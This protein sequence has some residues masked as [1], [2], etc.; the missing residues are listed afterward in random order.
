MSMSGN[1]FGDWIRGWLREF[2]GLSK[3][4]WVA[5]ALIM[6]QI[7]V[8]ASQGMVMLVLALS[9]MA[10]IFSHVFYLGFG[11]GNIL[12]LNSRIEN[13]GT[14]RI[15][16]MRAGI[17]FASPKVDTGRE[18]RFD[19]ETLQRGVS[20][21]GTTGSGKTTLLHAAA[22]EAIQQGGGVL[23][24]DGKGDVVNFA[25]LH[26]AASLHG[27]EDD[28]RVLNFYEDSNE[29]NTSTFDTF[30]GMS[31]GEAVDF[32]M[33]LIG[34]EVSQTSSAAGTLRD[35]GPRNSTSDIARHMALLGDGPGKIESFA[36]NPL[37]QG[38]RA[39][40]FAILPAARHLND[41]RLDFE[42]IRDLIRLER[43]VECVEDRN[44]PE[45]VT[46]PIVS[47]LE[48]LQGYVPEK[49]RKQSQRTLDQHGYAEMAL[50]KTL[51][52]VCSQGCVFSGK[53][54]HVTMQDMVRGRRIVLVMLPGLIHSPEKGRRLVETLIH[55]F[56]T[57]LRKSVE[58]DRGFSQSSPFLLLD[59]EAGIDRRRVLPVI[60]RAEISKVGYIGTRQD[61][62]QQNYGRRGEIDRPEDVGAVVLL[63]NE[64]EGA[65]RNLT[66]VDP[67]EI[68]N[69]DAGDCIVV[70]GKKVE[71]CRIDHPRSAPRSHMLGLSGMTRISERAGE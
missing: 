1:G 15:G 50:T 13:E 54:A 58:D 62:M 28:I 26:Y 34:V 63:R 57:E 56:L 11:P 46:A 66:M 9:F 12:G 32:I 59:D 6:A 45:H 14:I 69:Q 42:T 3:W 27:R 52:Q 47:Y 39:I 22:T 21:Y 60:S 40:A 10:A 25:K 2:R 64:Q 65:F 51:R 31:D 41:G 38:A 33:D 44:L 4:Y 49:G 23:Y 71:R 18:I 36:S 24:I 30:D 19:R 7:L 68:R 20:V 61:S 53:G 16:K 55:P 37:V 35:E 8:F 67:I 70:T 5:G 43:L 29:D 17:G 48:S